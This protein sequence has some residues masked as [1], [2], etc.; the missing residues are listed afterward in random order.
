MNDGGRYSRIDSRER[1]VGKTSVQPRVTLLLLSSITLLSGVGVRLSEGGVLLSEV[2][3]SFSDMVVVLP[4]VVVSL[5]GVIV[6]FRGVAALSG[7]VLLFSDMVDVFPVV[8]VS[9]PGVAILLPGVAVLS[10]TVVVLLGMDVFLQRIGAVKSQQGDGQIFLKEW[11]KSRQKSLKHTM[12]K[13]NPG[14][15]VLIDK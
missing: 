3:V 9:L 8:V 10:G 14:L 12:P 1:T 15:K 13:S 11:K 5:P 4:V 2:G 7:V 6:T